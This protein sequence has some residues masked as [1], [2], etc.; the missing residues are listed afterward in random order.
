MIKCR[1]I[2]EDRHN[3]INTSIIDKSCGLLFSTLMSICQT[4]ENIFIN[5]TFSEYS[6][7]HDKQHD[8][9]GKCDNCGNEKCDCNDIENDEECDCENE[10]DRSCL[11]ETIYDIEH[12]TNVY[13][14][15][16]IKIKKEFI[17]N[18]QS[19]NYCEVVD[20]EKEGYASNTDFSDSFF[21]NVY[22]KEN[23]AIK[24]KIKALADILDL[25]RELYFGMSQ[26]TRNGFNNDELYNIL[27]N[28]FVNAHDMF[29]EYDNYK[30]HKDKINKQFEEDLLNA[31]ITLN[32]IL[33]LA[34]SEI[35]RD[36]IIVINFRFK[37]LILDNFKEFDPEDFC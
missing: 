15:D 12:I 6:K 36:P 11:Y 17:D 2:D 23:Y 35:N 26:E 13:G 22:S 7:K 9:N 24:V 34:C 8:K 28:N 30:S 33:T 29:I 16:S 31:F 4:H 20:V 14:D 1:N 10:C 21:E 25:T 3:I 5:E 19:Y 32:D 27:K 18:D 37:R